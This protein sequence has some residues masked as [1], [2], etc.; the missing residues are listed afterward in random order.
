MIHKHAF[1]AS[2]RSL[3]DILCC[4]LRSNSNLLFD[5]KSIIFGGG[6]RH[7]LHVVHNGSREE[8]MNVSLSSSDV[9]SNW[10]VLRLT[11]NIKLS[12][13]TF[14]IEETTTFANC[15]LDIGEGKVR[16]L[17]NGKSIVDIPN[18]VFITIHLILLV[19]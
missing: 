14:D 11:K 17:N 19:R 2:D 13:Q 12:V 6:F 15:L 9:W 4:D 7:I 10:K 1:E 5:E 8:I 3:K 18:D 16:Y